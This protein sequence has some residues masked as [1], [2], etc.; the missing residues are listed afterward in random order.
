LLLTY[1]DYTKALSLVPGGGG[2]FDVAVNGETV[3]S[4]KAAGRYPEISELNE[5]INRY[6]K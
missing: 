2:V 1:A 5:A 6:L 4:K 3:F